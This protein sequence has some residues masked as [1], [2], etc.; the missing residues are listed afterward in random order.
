MLEGLKGSADKD[1]DKIITITDAYKYASENVRRW[2]FKKGLEQTP[3]LEAKVA[4]D[5]PFVLLKAALKKE[6]PSDKSVITTIT[7]RSAFCDDRTELAEG[8]CGSLLQFVDAEHINK[9]STREKY[10]FPYGTISPKSGMRGENWV[11]WVE[12]SFEYKKESSSKVDEIIHYFDTHYRW[13]SITYG[14]SERIDI[15]KLVEKCKGSGFRIISFSP[16]KEN[17]SIKADTRAWLDTE[18]TF[19]NSKESADICI[20]KK[21][22]NRFEDNFFSTLSPENFQEFIRNCLE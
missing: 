11:E 17:E 19:V 13:V 22:D 15:Q 20:L 1:G 8:M 14:L 5:I 16:L 12:L 18:T 2:A 21:F 6:K 4:G 10:Y 3:F 9:D 7:L